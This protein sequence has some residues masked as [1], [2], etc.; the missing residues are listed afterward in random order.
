M[1]SQ[2]TF[3]QTNKQTKNNNNNT[4]SGGWG[5]GGGGGGG[6]RKK[7]GNKAE[8]IAYISESC[9]HIKYP[10]PSCSFLA[11]VH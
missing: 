4:T 5:G 6:G 8:L 2:F 9:V 10:Q 11:L 7:R 1:L 3:K